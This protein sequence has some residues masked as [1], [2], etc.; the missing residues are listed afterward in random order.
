[1]CRTGLTKTELCICPN[2]HKVYSIT[3]SHWS[4]LLSY[5]Q[6]PW[7]TSYI[8]VCVCVCLYSHDTHTP[9][10][11]YVPCGQA[12]HAVLPCWSVDDP[13]SHRMQ[14]EAPGVGLYVPREP[15]YSTQEQMLP[16]SVLL[17]LCGALESASESA[18]HG[19]QSN[20]ALASKVLRGH[21]HRSCNTC[22]F[23]PP[24]VALHAERRYCVW[25]TWLALCGT[26]TLSTR[27]SPGRKRRYQQ[28]TECRLWHQERSCRCPGR[29]HSTDRATSNV[30]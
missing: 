17:A 15:V 2:S 26:H 14:N 4:S 30:D 25:L 13:G 5:G 28:H 27:R 29:L 19:C 8:C 12:E 6:L 16:L 22:I 11:E 21:M 23:M 10:V 3:R 20:N 9:V 24:Q 7:T 1:M 18:T